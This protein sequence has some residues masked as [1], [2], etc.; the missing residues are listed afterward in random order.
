MHIDELIAA[1]KPAAPGSYTVE[2]GE[3]WGQGRTLF[4]GIQSMLAVRAMRLL[5]PDAPALWSLQSTFVAPIAPGLVHIE[6]QV[7]RSGRAAVHMEARLLVDGQTACVVVAVFGAARSSSV[8]VDA[9]A[10]AAPQTV[11]TLPE[12]PF[13]PGITPNFTQH[14]VYRW[15]EGGFPFTGSTHPGTGIVL[16][17]R[18]AGQLEELHII[19]L[20][21]AIPP[22]LLSLL[23]QPTPASTLTWTL[24]FVRHLAPTAADAWWRMDAKI[25]SARDGYSSQDAHLFG[26]DGGLVLLSRQLVAVFG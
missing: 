3:D 5:Q 9:P 17:Q 24:E 18:D 10:M 8:S 25:V 2:V 4:G 1:V 22:P 23:S 20:A 21:D 6:A 14:Y 16:R 15:A 13:L 12:L 7:L 19:A 11:D 26:P